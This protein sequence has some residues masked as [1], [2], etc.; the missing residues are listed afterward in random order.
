VTQYLTWLAVTPRPP[1]TGVSYVVVRVVVYLLGLLVM[2]LV[3][4]TK[5]R[6]LVIAPPIGIIGGAGT[7][8]FLGDTPLEPTRRLVNALGTG[9][10]LAELT[11]AFGYWEVPALAGAAGLWLAFYVL[12]GVVEHTASETLDRRVAIEYA[13][14]ALIGSLIIAIVAHPWSV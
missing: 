4:G 8:Y 9:L 1:R 6:G 13:V 2:F 11:W 14:V 3:Y 5:Q 12:S 7:W 10:L